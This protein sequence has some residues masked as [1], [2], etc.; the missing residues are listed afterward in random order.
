LI[1]KRLKKKDLIVGTGVSSSTIAKMTKEQPV[2]L[3]VI[4][5]ICIFLNC[6]MNDVLQLEFLGWQQN[7]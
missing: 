2:N 6:N 7:V 5:R 1:D 3:E 4:A